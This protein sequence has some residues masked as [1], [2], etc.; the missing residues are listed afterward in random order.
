MTDYI[1]SN[2]AE[3]FLEDDFNS[4]ATEN[5]VLIDPCMTEDKKGLI[6]RFKHIIDMSFLQQDNLFDSSYIRQTLVKTTNTEAAE[7]LAIYSTQLTQN[8]EIPNQEII[9][10]MSQRTVYGILPLT[11]LIQRIRH[12]FIYWLSICLYLEPKYV[13]SSNV[14]HGFYDYIL[15][16]ACKYIGIP[17]LAFYPSPI[18]E[19][20]FLIDLTNLEYVMN[21]S[22]HTHELKSLRKKSINDYLSGLEESFKI[23]TQYPF[24]FTNHYST[25]AI[26][27]QSD[28]SAFRSKQKLKLLN[29]NPH[30]LS[31]KSNLTRK[32]EAYSNSQTDLSS[33]ID[34]NSRIGF[35]PLHYQPELS[36]CPMAFPYH[37]QRQLIEHIINQYTELDYLIVKEHPDQ[38]LLCY[39]DFTHD[40]HMENFLE[41]RGLNYYND[42]I[43]IS[44]KIKLLDRN[45]SINQFILEYNP[46]VYTLNG[47]VNIQSYLLGATTIILNKSSPYLMLLNN[48][49]V[50]ESQE[51]FSKNLSFRLEKLSSYFNSYL[52]FT[53]F[54]SKQIHKFSK[55]SILEICQ[56]II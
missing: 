47:T 15:T 34:P 8:F 36:T 10:T 18:I 12:I 41:Y 50:E 42:I 13:V 38:F 51:N 30:I 20:S 44:P 28:H 5:T 48:F 33:L 19:L 1:F 11:D 53:P 21:P 32:Y 35:L 23:S 16:S 6:H 3:L 40:K 24:G 17:Y 22:K 49:Y 43:S 52:W 31:H 7:I 26:Q 55:H 54:R 9:L 27:K 56:Y 39:T 2:F 29:S 25:Y 37:D 14:P 46:I 4:I 45:I